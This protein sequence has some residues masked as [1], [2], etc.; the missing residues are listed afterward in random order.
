MI[1]DSIASQDTLKTTNQ[2]LTTLL[3]K[4][5]EIEE[6]IHHPIEIADEKASESEADLFE[7]F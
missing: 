5:R 3:A 2:V 4:Q 7:L 6:L 1:T